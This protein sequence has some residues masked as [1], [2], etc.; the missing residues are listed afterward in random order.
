MSETAAS[1]DIPRLSIGMP[2]YNATRYLEA[3]FRSLLAQD[4]TD[5]E[6]IVSDNASTDGTW[7]ICER[8]AATDPRI[9]LYRNE[10]N[11]GVAANFNRVARLAR[12]E[13]FK[14]VAYD[15]LMEPSFLTA[16]VAELDRSDARTLLAYPR[17]RLIDDTGQL[18]SDYE[19]NLDIRNRFAFR[20]VGVFAWRWNHCNPIYGVIRRDALMRTGLERP[21]VSG[22]VPLLFE[23]ALH[24]QFHEV[25]ERLFLRRFHAASS[26]ENAEAYFHADARRRSFPR[27]RLTARILSVLLDAEAPVAVR[28]SSAASFL[29][30]W[31]LRNARMKVGKYYR[32]LLVDAVGER[33]HGALRGSG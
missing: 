18:V 17:T 31:G 5:F 21:Y 6:L 4:F 22:D 12:G 28:W 16:C 2:L 20:R 9:R 29:S 1:Q 13:L 10:R 26:R 25:P 32:A 30:V 11:L 3:S 23:L 24:G 19:D 33:R 27:L 14:W 7:E 15:D 8:F